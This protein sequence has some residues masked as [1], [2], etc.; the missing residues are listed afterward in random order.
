MNRLY[1]SAG[2]TWNLT[3][4]LLQISMEKNWAFVSVLFFFLGL[5][6]KKNDILFFR[7]FFFMQKV[8]RLLLV[9]SGHI[10]RY[11]TDLLFPRP[12]NKN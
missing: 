1:F 4:A 2:T 9:Y 12:A 3:W 7:K 8:K 11:V 6:L 10:V 5:V